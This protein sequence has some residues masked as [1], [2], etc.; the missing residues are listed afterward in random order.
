MT[1]FFD[2]PDTKILLFEVYRMLMKKYH[3]ILQES[4]NILK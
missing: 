4:A 2:T 3:Q 1:N